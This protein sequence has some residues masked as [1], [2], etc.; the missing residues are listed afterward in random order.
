MTYDIASLPSPGLAGHC[1]GFESSGRPRRGRRRHRLVTA[2]EVSST[3]YAF[4]GYDIPDVP[5]YHPYYTAIEGMA[6]LGIIE[7]YQNGNFGPATRS[8]AAIRQDDRAHHGVNDPRTSPHHERQFLFTDAPAMISA[9]QPTSSILST[10]VV[11]KADPHHWL[12]VGYP[13][14]SFRPANKITRAQVI[15]MIVRAEPGAP[16]TAEHV[17]RRPRYTDPTHGQNIQDCGVQRVSRRHRGNR[18]RTL[19]GWNTK[20]TPPRRW[21]RCSGTFCWQVHSP[22]RP[23]RLRPIVRSSTYKVQSLALPKRFIMG[24]ATHGGSGAVDQPLAL[25][26]SVI[27]ESFNGTPT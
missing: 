23:L 2:T 5:A 4:P 6:E 16:I 14:G 9:I 27:A 15:T 20:A 19:T 17:E 8:S 12:T 21:R 26:D 3:P 25:G 13:D 18:E 7:G 11:R 24:R 10:T 1:G 22:A